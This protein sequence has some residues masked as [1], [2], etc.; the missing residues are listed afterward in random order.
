MLELLIFILGFITAQYLVP[1]FDNLLV[2]LI[3][4]MDAKK[5]SYAEKINQSN[6]NMRKAAEE[7]PPRRLIGFN[8]SDAE[9]EEEETDDDV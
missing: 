1:F 6:I 2:L 8:T 7:E 9:E 5:S 3:T 4:K